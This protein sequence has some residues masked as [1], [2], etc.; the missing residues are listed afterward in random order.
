[1]NQDE[2]KRIEEL[3]RQWLDAALERGPLYYIERTYTSNSTD[4]PDGGKAEEPTPI[5]T[6][7]LKA[8]GE[9]RPQ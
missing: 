3:M 7:Y 8:F 2:T 5:P 6:V 9:E 1:M 4:W